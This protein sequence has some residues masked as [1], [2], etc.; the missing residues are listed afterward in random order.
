MASYF[1]ITDSPLVPLVLSGIVGIALI[2]LQIL[3]GK[4]QPGGKSGIALLWISGAVWAVFR[5]EL[6]FP[7]FTSFIF[8]VVLIALTA[9]WWHYSVRDERGNLNH[10]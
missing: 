2:L 7:R 10:Q 9:I 6:D 5:C 1:G 3:L 8:L 4:F